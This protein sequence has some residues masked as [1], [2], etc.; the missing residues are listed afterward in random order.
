MIWTRYVPG[1]VLCNRAIKMPIHKTLIYCRTRVFG[2]ISG[3]VGRVE[4]RDTSNSK[5]RCCEDYR[6]RWGYPGKRSPD[7]PG[8]RHRLPEWATT[9][10]LIRGKSTH[11][12]A[13]RVCP[14]SEVK[15]RGRYDSGAVPDAF[16]R[17]G[18][19]DLRG[20]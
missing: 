20:G 4:I 6:Y 17:E 11:R 1:Q 14:R 8:R 15:H 2:F 13:D 10:A 12:C 18:G 5:F 16:G 3:Q 9:Q 19:L 7:M